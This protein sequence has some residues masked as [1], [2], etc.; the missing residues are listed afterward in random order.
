MRTVRAVSISAIVGLSAFGLAYLVRGHSGDSG[1]VNLALIC[2]GLA[3]CDLVA[4]L[5]G[6][7]R[8]RR[9]LW[10][11]QSLPTSEVTSTPPDRPAGQGTPPA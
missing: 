1:V 10:S 7:V 9:P 8:T 2:A 11:G 3:V 5:G 6:R 4:G